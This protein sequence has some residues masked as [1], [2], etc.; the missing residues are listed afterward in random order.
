MN[1]ITFCD[2][3][4]QTFAVCT[5]E[6]EQQIVCRVAMQNPGLCKLMETMEIYCCG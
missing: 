4:K 6:I 2:L 3:L 1:D 5:S